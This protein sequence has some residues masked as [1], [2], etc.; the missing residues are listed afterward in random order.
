M[1]SSLPFANPHTSTL[2]YHIRYATHAFKIDL[3]TD[4]LP[5]M[6]SQPRQNLERAFRNMMRKIISDLWKG[7]L[8]NTA[9][10]HAG[11]PWAPGRKASYIQIAHDDLQR[12]DLFKPAQFLCIPHNQLPLLRLR[13]Q[14]T[15]Y[16]PTHLHLSI[17]HTYTLYAERYCLSCLP[18]QIPRDETHTLLHCPYF[19]PLTQPAIHSLMLNFRRFDLWN[20]QL[21][22]TLKK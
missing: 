6:T 22:Q 10:T 14:A 5:D 3:Q 16:I 18:L 20:G 4:P 15:S 1:N 9:R 11:Q 21:T 8:Y 7:Q 19:S 12:S 2:D 13:T 17:T